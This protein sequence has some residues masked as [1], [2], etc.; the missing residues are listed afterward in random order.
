MKK[1]AV[2]SIFMAFWSSNKS[3]DHIFP[4]VWKEVG[5]R[6]LL[7]QRPKAQQ[8]RG[9]FNAPWFYLNQET[10]RGFQ[11]GVGTLTNHS[12]AP[13]SPE[14]L[15]AASDLSHLAK[16]APSVKRNSPPWTKHTAGRRCGCMLTVKARHCHRCERVC[17]HTLSL[18]HDVHNNR[19]L[20][21]GLPSIVPKEIVQL[22]V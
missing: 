12:T 5:Q 19:S 7:G 8:F 3:D 21:K 18:L 6:W 15:K 14:L 2:L 16:T 4:A 17:E 10:L 1:T 13:L 20:A 9:L 11:W 22:A